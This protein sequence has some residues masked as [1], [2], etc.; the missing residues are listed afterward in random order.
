MLQGYLPTLELPLPTINLERV[1]LQYNSQTGYGT[2]QAREV[3]GE[4]WRSLEAAVQPA[5]E[6]GPITWLDGGLDAFRLNFC[7]CCNGA[8]PHDEGVTMLFNNSLSRA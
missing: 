3:D 6:G 5:S 4:A 7:C 2:Q 1:G 8:K